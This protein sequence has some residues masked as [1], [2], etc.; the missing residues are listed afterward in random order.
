[1]SAFGWTLLIVGTMAFWAAMIVLKYWLTS[2][3]AREIYDARAGEDPLIASLSCDEFTKIFQRTRG[4]RPAIFAFL[5]AA[6][7]LVLMPVIFSIATW[8]VNL[9]WNASGRAA[10]FDEGF[11]PWLFVVTLLIIAGWI[12]IGAVFAR[13]YYLNKPQSL[14]KELTKLQ[15]QRP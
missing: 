15:E 3:T 8:I 6:T 1:M 5:A 12:A 4:P 11:A 10:D 9:I 2:K 7:A 14:E 13:L